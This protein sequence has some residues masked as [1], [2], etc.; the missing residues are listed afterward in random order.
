MNARLAKK[1]TRLAQP[2]R[3]PAATVLRA[4]AY[5]ERRCSRIAV[6]LCCGDCPAD[7][8]CRRFAVCDE[9]AQLMGLALDID[10]GRHPWGSWRCQMQRPKEAPDAA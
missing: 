2:G 7:P 3:Y 6:P 9:E 8:A 1:I 5:R 10:N 4:I